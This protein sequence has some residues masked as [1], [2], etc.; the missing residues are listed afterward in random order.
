MIVPRSSALDPCRRHR[1]G[2]VLDRDT[3]LPIQQSC[4]FLRRST[5]ICHLIGHFK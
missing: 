5:S 4:V 3:Q 2:D 1:A